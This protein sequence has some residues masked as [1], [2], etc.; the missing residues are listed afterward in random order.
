MVISDFDLLMVG[1]QDSLAKVQEH[2]KAFNIQID[3]LWYVGL[4]LSDIV[5][6]FPKIASLRLLNFRQ[7]NCFTKLNVPSAENR[8]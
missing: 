5:N 6:F 7:R 1:K 3:N 4:D 8:W 2:M